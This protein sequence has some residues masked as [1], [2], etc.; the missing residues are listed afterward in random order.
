M[1]NRIRFKRECIL[2]LV[3]RDAENFE[4]GS[5]IYSTPKD[6]RT[7]LALSLFLWG[8]SWF[9]GF[10]LL[11]QSIIAPPDALTPFEWVA[12][13]FGFFL[14]FGLVPMIIPDSILPPHFRVYSNGV[15]KQIGHLFIFKRKGDFVPH[16][17][18]EA[19]E[20]SSDGERCVIYQRQGKPAYYWDKRNMPIAMLKEHL[21]GIG[22][23]EVPVDCPKCSED[24][25]LR[26]RTCPRCSEKRF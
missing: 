21:V 2:S 20:C 23:K 9:V 11:I 10:L 7:R 12:G 14:L 13:A 8:F 26:G 25:L 15:T 18:M 22:V 3:T 24:L 16:S 17:E 1:G 6:S 4:T 5:L 19:F